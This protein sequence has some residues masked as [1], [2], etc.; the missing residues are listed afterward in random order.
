MTPE[1]TD[2]ARLM[3]QSLMISQSRLTGDLASMKFAAMKRVPQL[4]EAM[5]VAKDVIK[6]YPGID[7]GYILEGPCGCGKSHIL[8]ATVHRFIENGY[9]AEFWTSADYLQAIRAGY[10]STE[11]TDPTPRLC[12]VRILAYDDIGAE[13]INAKNSEWVQEQLLTLINARCTHRLSGRLTL[14]TTNL[15]QDELRAKIGQR[16]LDRIL[17]M[18][19]WVTIKAP[20]YRAEIQRQHK[21]SRQT[22]REE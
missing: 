6:R 10:N 8:A 18:C 19:E 9:Q 20:S 7:H 11:H 3:T 16:S 12:K 4:V 22:E 17:E 15:S 14:M 2:R 1:E 5:T 13:N 21:L